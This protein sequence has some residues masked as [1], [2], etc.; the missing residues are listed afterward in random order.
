MPLTRPLLLLSAL[1]VAASFASS[2]DAREMIQGSGRMVTETRALSGFQDIAAGG[3][4][5]L[6]LR[7]S[8]KEGIEIRADDNIVPLIE[9]KV[10]GGRLEIG[11]RK[12][13]SYSTRNEIVVTVDLINLR[14]LDIGGSVDVVGNGLKTKALQVSLGGSGEVNLPDLQA[15]DLRINVGGSGSLAASGKGRKIDIAIGGSGDVDLEAF[16][17]DDVTVDVAGSGSAGVTAN[18]TLRAAIAGSGDV[19]YRG[20]ANVTKSVAGSGSV[21]RK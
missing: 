18:K 14:R 21:T 1:S 19:T 3:S 11:S 8:G 20:D 15:T 13:T 12:N 6:V 7:Q 4:M 2:A 10:V 5:Q 16:D 17:A 9:T